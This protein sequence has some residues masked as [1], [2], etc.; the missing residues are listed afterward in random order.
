M[1]DVLRRNNV[2]VSGS[3]SAVVFGHGLGCDQTVWRSVAPRFTRDH[4][5]ILFDYVGCGAS[6]RSAYDPARYGALNGYAQDLVEIVRALELEGAT[7]V[8]HSVSG[9]IGIL[10]SLA[11]PELFG[12]MVLLAPSPRFLN[13]PPDYV[14]GMERR[15]VSDFLDLMEQNFVDW[16]TMFAGIVAPRADVAKHMA[17]SF[18]A[19]DPR[20][21][22]P[23][24]ELTL[25]HDV[26]SLLP[27]VDVPTLIVQSSDDAVAPVGV[28][29][30]M[31][32]TI[33]ASSYRLLNVEGHCP[34]LS[35]PDVVERV[36]RE[37]LP[38]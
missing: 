26:R 14:G 4:R 8:G 29:Q 12:R 24:A 36:V 17:E 13:D 7:F 31:H 15:D 37:F 10:A 27:R 25:L 1:T 23:F 18:R 28:G 19:T 16:S 6:D 30:F 20:T 33:P 38:S 32:R 3:G 22:R 5:V 21:L 2:L 34:H 35:H 9:S 11:A